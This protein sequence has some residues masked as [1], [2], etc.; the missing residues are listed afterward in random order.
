MVLR[1]TL[2][3]KGTFPRHLELAQRRFMSKPD[4]SEGT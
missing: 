4:P 1:M 2:T 3:L